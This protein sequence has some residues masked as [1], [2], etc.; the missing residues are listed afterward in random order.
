MYPPRSS[1]LCWHKLQ[2]KSPCTPSH[3]S[4]ICQ[5]NLWVHPPPPAPIQWCLLWWNRHY[6]I[7]TL[8]GEKG[9]PHSSDIIKYCSQNSLSR[10]F[11]A[12]WSRCAK[13]VCRG[14]WHTALISI[15]NAKR[16]FTMFPHACLIICIM[17]FTV[18]HKMHTEQSFR[19]AQNASFIFVLTVNSLRNKLILTRHLVQHKQ[20]LFLVLHTFQ[21]YLI[22]QLSFVFYILLYYFPVLWW[23]A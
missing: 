19:S 14:L 18:R 1:N 11:R 13:D 16:Y 4:N 22:S 20:G 10:H 17:R 7:A 15:V 9:A 21:V 2:A 5:G 12:I 3:F 8:S 6:S 23:K